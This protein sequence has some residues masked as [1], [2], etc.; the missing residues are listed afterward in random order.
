[1]RATSSRKQVRITIT[2]KN[3]TSRSI[4]FRDYSP[5]CSKNCWTSKKIVERENQYHQKFKS[6]QVSSV[7]GAL[8]QV[9]LKMFKVVNPVL[10]TVMSP[11]PA[12]LTICIII[13]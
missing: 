8:A 12:V 4:A 13:G 7:Q 5:K 9:F 3:T 1:M 2:K 10:V 11:G 6:L